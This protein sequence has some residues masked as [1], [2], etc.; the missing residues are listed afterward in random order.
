MYKACVRRTGASAQVLYRSVQQVY[1]NSVCGRIFTTEWCITMNVVPSC[2]RR[3]V[4]S[5]DVCSILAAGP[6]LLPQALYTPWKVP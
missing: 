1:E 3:C 6:V 4:T 5:E 2:T